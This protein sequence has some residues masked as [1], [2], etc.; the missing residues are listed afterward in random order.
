MG[1]K[2]FRDFLNGFIVVRVEGLNPEKFINI[3]SR[4]G[5]NLWDINK[6][7]YTVI[8]FKMKHREYKYL[9]DIV[10]KTSSRTKII[11]KKGFNFLYGKVRRR[12]FFILGIAAFLAI[13][14][15]LS[16]LVWIIDITGYKKISRE[17]IY[18]TLKASGL[19]AGRLKSKINLR[20]VENNVLKQMNGISIINIKFI[21]TRARV[22]IVERTMPPDILP[23]DKPTNIVASKDGII[24]KVLSYKG[25]PL[26]QVDDYVKRGQILISGVI[27][28][29]T[30]VPSKIVHAMGIVSAKTWYE[31]KKEVD[32]DYKFEIPTGRL[33]KKVYYNI[34]GRKI[35]VKNDKIDF[36]YYDKTEEKNFLEIVN[37]E[38]PIE[39]ITEYY[40]EKESKTTKLSG[41][42]AI[43]IA[44]SEAE[45]ELEGKLPDNPQILEKNIE[46]NIEGN[47][48]VVRV[49]CIVNENIGVLE[50][51][52]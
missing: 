16:N 7:S 45:K 42:E 5:I 21:G 39:V 47:T 33:K 35:C 17:L 1:S 36:K 10:K 27:T 9:K 8:E 23:L 2:D 46:K 40:Y 18:D 3:C 50:E 38:T 19:N 20:E 14:L 48:A 30:N 24:T 52:K 43:Q 11:K 44:I 13:I 6:K 28:D 29:N 41:E 25:Q 4:N 49:L 37:Y 51:I 26:V 31:A 34:M 12:K 32:L 22:E 15:Y